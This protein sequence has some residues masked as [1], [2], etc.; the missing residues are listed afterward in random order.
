MAER[1]HTG[2]RGIAF[3]FF[4]ALA[5]VLDLAQLVLLLLG[6]G[7]L[8]NRIL[9][10][11]FM[12]LL[13][14]YTLISGGSWGGQRLLGIG[15]L[16]GDTLIPIIGGVFPS[17]ALGTFFLFGKQKMAEAPATIKERGSSPKRRTAEPPTA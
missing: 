4:F 8:L 9:G 12:G 17:L 6:I 14:L 15:A 5:L 1:T 7:L 3:G 11:L 13:M 10:A 2:G 16:A